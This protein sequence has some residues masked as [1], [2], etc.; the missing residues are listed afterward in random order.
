MSKLKNYDKVFFKLLCLI[1]QHRV[2]GPGL[3]IVHK[4]ELKIQQIHTVHDLK[5]AMQHIN[6]QDLPERSF[7]IKSQGT[8]CR[9]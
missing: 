1:K 6:M 8:N 7:K 3:A 9:L 2:P 4:I 5:S